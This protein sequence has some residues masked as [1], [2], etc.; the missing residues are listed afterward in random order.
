M[1]INADGAATYH[2]DFNIPTT[3]PGY[4]S[5]THSWLIT[6]AS[7][8]PTPTNA[9]IIDGT[10]QPGYAGT[11]LIELNSSAISNSNTI[12]LNFAPAVTAATNQTAAEGSTSSLSLGSF[13]NPGNSSWAVDVNWGDSTSHTTFTT[14]S[15]GSLGSQAHSYAEEGTYTVSIKVTDNNGGSDN[16]TF[17]VTVADSGLVAG[18]FTPPVAGSVATEGQAFTN[19]TIFHFTDADPGN[20]AGDYTALVTRGDGTT[21]TLTSTAS[22]NGQIVANASGGFD[23]QLSYTYAEELSGKTFSVSVSDAGSAV[24]SAATGSFNV[25]DF[26]PVVSAGADTT[27]YT[28]AAYTGSGSFTDAGADSWTGTVNYGDGSGNQTLTLSGSS[29]NLS[30]TYATDGQYTVTVNITDDEGTVGTGSFVVTVDNYTVT[31]TSDSGGGSLRQALVNANAGVQ[32]TGTHAI[33]FNIPGSGVH[34]IT[35][36][37]VLPTISTPVIIDGTSQPS[38]AGMPL[39][40]LDGSAIPNGNSNTNGLSVN[41]TSTIKGLDIHGFYSADVILGT[42]GNGSTFTG[43]YVGTDST[44]NAVA[45]SSNCEILVYGSNNTIS[46]NVSVNNNDGAEN[47][48]L[49][50]ATPQA[51]S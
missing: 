50:G 42:G 40:E 36:A 24:T 28:T 9:V 33:N 19:A 39:I 43:N 31:T 22:A 32:G 21:V 25:A 12:G 7:I 16:K 10:S 11:P 13:T 27:I 4:N 1:T 29:F 17:Q 51:T 14:T 46:N 23:V 2:I 38:Y 37:S 41:A 8:L 47:V 34:T 45:G 48:W 26:T 49:N 30:H 35:V 15:T 18:A 44:G 6:P 5:T 3:D 20:S